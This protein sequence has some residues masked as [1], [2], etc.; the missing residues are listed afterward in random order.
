MAAAGLGALLDIHRGS[1]L[2]RRTDYEQII[3]NLAH[4][5]PGAETPAEAVVIKEDA[6]E[7]LRG[8]RL[9]GCLRWFDDG[10]TDTC[11]ESREATPELPTRSHYR[12]QMIGLSS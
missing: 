10:D 4:A 9:Q 2:S 1:V 12:P 8:L 5:D 7:L 3:A 11:A 6:V